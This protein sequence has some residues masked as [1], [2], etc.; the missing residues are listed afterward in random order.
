MVFRSISVSIIIPVYNDE[1]RIRDS[2]I[3]IDQKFSALDYSYEVLVV[4]DGST[5]NSRKFVMSL[6]NP[7]VKVS[8]YEVNRG[9]GYALKMGVL[10]AEGDY[11]VFLDSG[12]EINI[13]NLENYLAL[14]KISDIVIGS[15]KH[16]DSSVS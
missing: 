1:T 5:D 7:R 6:K 15:K 4:D 13:D 10:K 16:L 2:V 12:N 3:R 8:G 11:I 9:K 14:L